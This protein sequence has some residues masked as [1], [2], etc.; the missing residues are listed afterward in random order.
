MTVAEKLLKAA[1]WRLSK[2]KLEGV[3]N[4][5]LVGYSFVGFEYNGVKF[6]M[7]FEQLEAIERAA[8]DGMR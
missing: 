5:H 7:S 1:E 3:R 6:K 4:P 8:N 2:Q